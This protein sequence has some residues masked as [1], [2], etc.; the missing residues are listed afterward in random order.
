MDTTIIVAIVAVAA[1]LIGIFLGKQLFAKNNCNVLAL[2]RNV[3]PLKT[4]NHKNITT[5]SVDLSN[6]NSD[7]KPV[8]VV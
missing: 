8:V 1:I 4:I 6:V 5:L 2:S 3:E 7:V